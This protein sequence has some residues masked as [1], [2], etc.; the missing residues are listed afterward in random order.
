M[1][2]KKG[3]IFIF[4]YQKRLLANG[5]TTACYFGSLHLEGT[6]ELVNSVISHGQRALVGKVSMNIMN[7]AGYFNKTNEEL[8][9]V[10][11]FVK[12][13]IEYKVIL[14]SF[15]ILI[16]KISTIFIG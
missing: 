7:G 11:M 4:I 13:V 8:E 10:D 15:S 2:H 3:N 9:Q 5:T 6:L 1:C 12:K 14:C 16:C